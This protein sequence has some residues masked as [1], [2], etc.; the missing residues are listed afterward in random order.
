MIKI[1]ALGNRHV[2]T[3]VAASW[4][5]MMDTFSRRLP[6]KVHGESLSLLNNHD[7]L[8]N[9]TDSL[10]NHGKKGIKSDATHLI[11]TLLSNGNF[12]PQLWS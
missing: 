2:L 8:K 9:L 12:G 4:G 11:T 6:T 10:N 7:S 5:H 3:T 1:W